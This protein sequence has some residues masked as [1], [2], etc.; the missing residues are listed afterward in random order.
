MNW[1]Q[2]TDILRMAVV[3]NLP[4]MRPCSMNCRTDISRESKQTEENVWAGQ[5]RFETR[6]AWQTTRLQNLEI[7]YSFYHRTKPRKTNRKKDITR[8]HC[9]VKR[10][11]WILLSFSLI[12]AQKTAL[13][14]RRW[15]NFSHVVE[16]VR[17]R[18]RNCSL[19]GWLS[20]GVSIL[21]L[22]FRLCEYLNFSP[23]A[24]I[25]NTHTNT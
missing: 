21:S 10:L 25:I 9:I 6:T 14:A 15:T 20:L 24:F 22:Y 8:R 19:C 1:K 4:K 17:K 3:C 11:L 23:D 7:F 18:A 2:Q 16:I 13:L 5:D 12:T